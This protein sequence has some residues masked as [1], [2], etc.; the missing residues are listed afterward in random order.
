MSQQ[1]CASCDELLRAC[2]FATQYRRISPGGAS[3]GAPRSAYLVSPFLCPLFIVEIS[4]V[5]V[6]LEVIVGNHNVNAKIRRL[7]KTFKEYLQTW[8]LAT[9]FR[10]CFTIESLK[11]LGFPAQTA[12]R[13]S[14][15]VSVSHAAGST[16]HICSR[17]AGKQSNTMA[18]LPEV[19]S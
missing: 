6:L 11:S 18:P 4:A 5:W 17:C 8:N 14:F 12:H 1:P 16:L 2:V 13:S 10:L 15:H 7:L 19:L 3:C 9:P